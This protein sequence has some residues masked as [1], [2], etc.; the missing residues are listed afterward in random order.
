MDFGKLPFR[1]SANRDVEEARPVI[2][3]FRELLMSQMGGK[4]AQATR[5]GR[6][7]TGN[8]AAAG[9]VIPIYS[10]TAQKVGIWNPKGSGVDVELIKIGQTY[11]DTTQA[12]GG[13]VLGL[14][15]NAPANLGTGGEGISAF[16]DGTLNT[17]IFNGLVGDERGPKARF[18]PSAAAVTAPIVLR[19]LSY[20]Q[21]AMPATGAVN[22]AKPSELVFDGDLWVPPGNA[23]F[24]AG[25]IATLVKLAVSMTWC[26]HPR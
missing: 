13:F 19:H 5:E 9:A 8:M 10:N 23:I 26:E 12:A 24:F 21:D 18:T 20:N 16:T 15:K 1:N 7:F 6:V 17:D 4:Y 14:V 11:I 22:M 3:A 2:G 25:N